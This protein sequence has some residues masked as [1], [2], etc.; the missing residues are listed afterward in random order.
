VVLLPGTATYVFG[1][2]A[3]LVLCATAQDQVGIN[4]TA[5]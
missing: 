3:T 5:M 4:L 1:D 2:P